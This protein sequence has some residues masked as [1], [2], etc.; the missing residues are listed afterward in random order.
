MIRLTDVRREY[1]AMHGRNRVLNGVN[2]EIERGEKVGI[3]GKNG[4]GKSTL[5]R[6]ISGAEQPNAGKV[7][8]NMSVSWPLAF[9]GG[10]QST[11][12]GLDNLR[13]ICRIYQRDWRAELDFVEDFTE[14]GHFLKEP[15]GTYSSGMR[16]RLA[17]ALSMV[18][19]FDCF[20]IDEVMAVGDHR[21][22][23]RCNHELF[24]KR[25]HKAMI[26]VSH[27][28]GFIRDHCKRAS[29]LSR[30]ILHNFEDLEQAFHFYYAD[31]A[32]V[33]AAKAPPQASEL[34]VRQGNMSIEFLLFGRDAPRADDRF[35]SSFAD[36]VFSHPLNEDPAV[37]RHRLDTKVGDAGMELLAGAF[38][39]PLPPEY[40]WKSVHSALAYYAEERPG[41]PPAERF[42][43]TFEAV[44][45][46]DGENGLW[47][48]MSFE[49][50]SIRRISTFH[51]APTGRT[52]PIRVNFFRPATEDHVR[53]ELAEFH[54]TPNG[55]I[56][57]LQSCQQLGYSVRLFGSLPFLRK[58]LETAELDGFFALS[59]G[60]EGYSA[61]VLSFCAPT[62]DYL[63]VDPMFVE[64]GGYQAQRAAY[65]EARAWHDREDKA[66]WRGTDTGV[67]RYRN[68]REAPR[69]VLAQLAN[70]RPELL[71][72][73]ITQ[74][75]QLP[76]WEDKQAFY[77]ENGLLGAAEPQDRILDF[78]YQIDVDGNSNSWPGLFL[79]LLSGSPVLK[80]E[81]EA[82]FKQWYY[83]QL[84]PWENFVPVASDG[85][86]LLE[87]LDWLRSNPSQAQAIGEGGRALALSLSYD[88]ALNSA[89]NTISRLVRMNRRFTY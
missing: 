65:N 26:F 56:C 7:E 81:S 24:E 87:K 59:L 64:T 19:D 32:P 85:S 69:V 9:G 82:G 66:Y 63:V 84:K 22:H 37:A 31:Y 2:F 1:P 13:F 68:F 60:D 57:T 88:D 15:L 79:K 67:F 36:W 47:N 73:K 89:V 33:V 72:A 8:R 80:F 29:V 17:F 51:H 30:G 6:L 34:K 58:F 28:P 42:L 61:R 70:A 78:R 53:N 45:P 38:A 16:S 43:E 74:V 52:L 71:D 49:G 39:S 11:L 3:L 20:L 77:A 41:S 14:L 10:F 54:M 25:G 18:V 55:V 86:D 23:E 40:S 83:H 46:V 76:G 12:T 21:F 27:D 75:Q 48:R 35:G 4:A 44:S 50:G 62:P 5:I